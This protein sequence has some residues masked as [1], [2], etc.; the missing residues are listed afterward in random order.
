LPE[1]AVV[2]ARAAVGVPLGRVTAERRPITA[3]ENTF[4]RPGFAAWLKTFF[5]EEGLPGGVVGGG[6]PPPL[7][8]PPP[9]LEAWKAAKAETVEYG[10]P[11]ARAK[12]RLKSP[13]SDALPARATCGDRR[14][15]PGKT[16]LGKRAAVAPLYT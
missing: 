4:R 10:P 13:G 1:L 6:A 9:P 15:T 2:S 3:S 14:D 5:N 8:P 11:R 16:D 7:A 12:A